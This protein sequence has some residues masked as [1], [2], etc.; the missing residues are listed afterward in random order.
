VE[1]P[2]GYGAGFSAVTALSGGDAW[3]VGSY[4]GRSRMRAFLERWQADSWHI[5]WIDNPGG[6]GGTIL[7]DVSAVDRQD[8]WA[9]G[10]ADVSPLTLHW[11]GTEWRTTVLP[12]PCKGGSSIL[13]GV[14]NAGRTR[15]GRWGH[16]PARQGTARPS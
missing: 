16:V 8:V 9:V 5:Q 1:A 14:A 2:Q 4:L 12:Q 10:L 11:N 6:R 7:Q 15:C 13:S 3:A